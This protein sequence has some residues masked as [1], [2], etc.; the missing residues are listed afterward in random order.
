MV[1]RRGGGKSRLVPKDICE[2]G[3]GGEGG[4]ASGGSGEGVF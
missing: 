3:G 1:V 2:A 4:R